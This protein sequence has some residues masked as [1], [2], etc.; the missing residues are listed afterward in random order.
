M[1]LD[2]TLMGL[3]E[4]LRAAFGHRDWWPGETPF[5]VMVG[6]ILTQRT[7]WRNVEKAVEA[8][9]EARVL[10]PAELAGIR[11]D[12]LE[13]LVRPAGYFRQKSA[14]LLALCKWLM[15]RTDGDLGALA[16]VPTD[17]L[18]AELLGIRGIGPETA[19]SIL[20]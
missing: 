14:R 16:P 13:E 15:D 8:L 3:Y 10:E 4:A 18:R 5:E 20:L 17:E 19:D 11:P 9:R 1:G 12:R 2:R 7:S 6:A